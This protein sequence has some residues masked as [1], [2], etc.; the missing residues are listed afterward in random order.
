MGENK[1]YYSM[2]N[3]KNQNL[4]EIDYLNLT[5]YN[6]VIKAKKLSC[7]IS[8]TNNI[9]Y[10]ICIYLKDGRYS[11]I[12]LDSL[13]NL[14]NLFPLEVTISINDDYFKNS[15]FAIHLRDN[16]GVFTYYQKDI[17]IKSN[18]YLDIINFIFLENNYSFEYIIQNYKITIN[19]N[20]DHQ[21]TKG[22]TY[23]YLI[24][25]NDNKFT[26]SYY[27]SNNSI[28]VIVLFDLF[29][30]TNLFV[31]YYKIDL[32]LYPISFNNNLNLFLYK[33][34]LGIGFVGVSKDTNKSQSSFIIFGYNDN[35]NTEIILDIYKENQGFVLQ[36]NNYFSLNNNLFGYDLL[37]KIK[38]ISEGLNGL[39]IFSINNNKELTID[40]IVLGN[41]SILFDLTS[42][43]TKFDGENSIEIISIISEPEFDKLSIMCDKIDTIGNANY[44]LF[45]EKQIIEEKIYKLKLNFNC[46]EYSNSCKCDKL[47]IKKTKNNITCLSDYASSS[48][49]YNLF[50]LYLDVK[51]NENDNC[52]DEIIYNYYYLDSCVE[53]YPSDAISE[54]INNNI[55]EI[56][57]DNTSILE[58]PEN[59]CQP[60]SNEFSNI[61]IEKDENTEIFNKICFYNYSNII[62]NLAEMSKNNIKINEHKG[63]TL[64][65]YSCNSKYFTNFD[66]LLDNNKNLTLIDIEECISLYK[67]FYN[68]PKE[69][70][71]YIIIIDTPPKYSNETTNRFNYELYFSNLTKIDNLDICKDIKIKVYS[72]ITNDNLID[73]NITLMFYEQGYD[74]FNKND[75]F[76]TDVCSSASLNKNDIILLDRYI[77]IYPHNINICPKNCE[78]LGINITSKRIICDCTIKLG[79]YEYELLTDEE[80]LNSFKSNFNKVIQYLLDLIN[81]KIILCYK[82]LQDIKKSKNN[83]ALFIG[84]S[85]FSISFIL[86]LLFRILGNKNLKRMIY[87]NFVQKKS[88]DKSNFE[89]VIKKESDKI[90]NK[91]TF[92]QKYINNVN[93]KIIN[94]ETISMSGDIKSNDNLNLYKLSS[95]SIK[96]YNKKDYNNNQIND[97]I[98]F[99][100]NNTNINNNNRNIKEDIK[101]LESNKILYNSLNKKKIVNN[102]TNNLKIKDENTDI[103]ELPYIKAKEKDKRHLVIIFNVPFINGIN[104][105]P[106]II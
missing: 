51:N 43:N 104:K 3:L 83:L 7:F 62:L 72:P 26:Y 56:K 100:K 95:N 96:K 28:I 77:D 58:C 41:D 1:I 90:S 78:S 46:Y 68:I 5:N 73:Y 93:K 9:I 21:S 14:I 87:I 88:I 102:E 67:Q 16:I 39:K 97:L 24:K 30:N 13:L 23:E 42:T 38:S 105:F 22:S 31:R 2:S 34:F 44:S 74:I 4:T 69:I 32:N 27:N 49:E 35:D 106:L 63:I 75:K 47:T 37:I 8:E 61:C 101:S 6:N 17:G 33:S 91:E 80:L 70:D 79:D 25:I 71:I 76:Y 98:Y 103:N 65:A 48:E 36:L 10:I 29:N 52:I 59:T 60:Q 18:L 85:F 12:C 53:E 57:N 89:K 11:I 45:Y 92:S 99:E 66:E 86:L 81:Y 64:S 19:N 55:Q 20:Y 50:K 54:E 84:I 15:F 82:L 94:I 40:E